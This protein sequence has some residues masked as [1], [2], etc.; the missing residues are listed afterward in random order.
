MKIEELKT[1]DVLL[2]STNTF[3]SKAIQWFEKCKYSHASLVFDVWNNKLVSEAERQGLMANDIVTSI[4]KCDMLVLRPKFKVNQIDLDLLVAQNLGKHRYN[5]LKLIVV[6]AVWQLTH[7][8]ILNEG[9][10]DKLK[11]V[12]C[13]EWVVYVYYT[14]SK[15]INF[16]RWYRDT[17]ASIYQSDLFDHFPLEK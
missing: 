16:N 7:K 13:G 5:F 1:G 6:Q 15:G 12:I 9:K 8:W 11:R 2:Y 3:L 4:G 10:N 17:P 14:L